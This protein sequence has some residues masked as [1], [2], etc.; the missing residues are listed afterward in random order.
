MCSLE[1]LKYKTLFFRLATVRKDVKRQTGGDME[2]I[3]S[4]CKRR[5]WRRK[6]RKRLNRKPDLYLVLF[7]V[8][9]WFGRLKKQTNKQSY[10]LF[11]KLSKQKLPLQVVNKTW[12][13]RFQSRWQNHH[14]VE[15]GDLSREIEIKNQRSACLLIH[16]YVDWAGVTKASLSSRSASVERQEASS[17]FLDPHASSSQVFECRHPLLW[18]HSC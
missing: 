3:V 14:I 10:S 15:D 11:Q 9:C 17:Y 13:I 12:L 18:L 6:R 16:I 4:W 2:T 5:S 1:I 8:F 7:F